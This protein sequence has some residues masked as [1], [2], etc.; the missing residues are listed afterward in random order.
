MTRLRARDTLYCVLRAVVER[1]G[2]WERRMRIRWLG[3][4]DRTARGWR[5][6]AGRG[7]AALTGML[8][9]VMILAGCSPSSSGTSGAKPALT[10]IPWC[11]RP[12][13]NFVDDSTQ[14]QPPI[15]DWNQVRDQLG[16]TLYLPS[17]LPKGSCLVLAGGSVHD[18]IYGAHV[19]L[20]WD[21]APDM[22]PLSFSEAPRRG[23]G[24]KPQCEASSQDAKVSICLGSIKDTSIT[25]VARET[26]AQLQSFFNGLQ[27]NVEWLPSDT[28]K[29]LAT[30]SPTAQS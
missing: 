5:A 8:L 4:D 13:F 6:W 24:A 16:F 11:D 27:P 26:P 23:A 7:V 2:G 22:S 29:L 21:V 28:Q 3:G 1:R 10:S 30:P 17:S 18:P 20:T 14:A 25:V 9:V 15:N 12:S 19:S